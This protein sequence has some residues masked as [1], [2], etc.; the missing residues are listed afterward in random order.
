MEPSTL[1]LRTLMALATREVFT[2]LTLPVVFL[3]GA[4]FALLII[5]FSPIR[6]SLVKIGQ[7]FQYWKTCQI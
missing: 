5:E 3:L 6:S 2:F 7:V 4:T 1:A